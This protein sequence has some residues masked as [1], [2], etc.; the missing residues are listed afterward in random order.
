MLPANMSIHPDL[1][2]KCDIV[3][4]LENIVPPSM[5][6]AVR[7]EGEN[8]TR[9]AAAKQ[10]RLVAMGCSS[11]FDTMTSSNES[12][13]SSKFRISAAAVYYYGI[14]THSIYPR[15]FQHHCIQQP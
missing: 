5:V 6:K 11:P 2:P 9:M 8:T 10:S 12:N 13:E 15:I 7:K 14:Q 4:D 1:V 3:P